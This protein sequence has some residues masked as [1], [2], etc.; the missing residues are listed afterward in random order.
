LPEAYKIPKPKLSEL[1]WDWHWQQI[2]V[3]DDYCSPDGY[4]WPHHQD[5]A[6]GI[7]TGVANSY[8]WCC[9]P[10]YIL[11]PPHS[12]LPDYA[13]S[14]LNFDREIRLIFWLSKQGDDFESESRVML[15]ARSSLGG[16]SPPI[17]DA[18]GFGILLDNLTLK[19]ESYG[20]AGLG[21]IDLGVCLI[22][23]GEAVKVEIIHYPGKRVEYWI[24]DVLRG[25]QTDLTKIPSGTSSAAADAGAEIYVTLK[26]GPTGGAPL[27]VHCTMP[28]VLQ[29]PPVIVLPTPPPLTEVAKIQFSAGEDSVYSLAIS[30]GY[31]YAGLLTSPGKVVKIDLSTFSKVS[32][33]TLDVAEEYVYSLAVSGGYLYA[34]LDTSPG[35]IV[36]IDLA[37]FTKVSSLTLAGGENYAETLVV[38]GNYLYAGLWTS[39]AKIVKIDLSTFTKVSTLTLDVA[40]SLVGGIVL[41]DDGYLYV[42]TYTNPAKIVK[43]D[44]ASLSKVSTL[45]LAAGEQNVISLVT[46]GNFLYAG[47]YT[48][49]GTPK[50]VKVDLTTFTKVSVLTSYPSGDGSHSLAISG[51]YLYAPLYNTT[52]AR[53]RQVSLTTFTYT[54]TFTFGS[55]EN[56]P[57]ALLISGDIIYVGTDTSPA[58]LVK[59]K[60]G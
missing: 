59:V 35:K 60:I 44:P 52:P 53:L 19:G 40:E 28:L 49:G 36:K 30:G 3:W 5:C 37:T 13:N 4:T 54:R 39:P 9:G 7:E 56:Y 43:I 6:V 46:L 41:A 48:A 45:T 42:G 50:H 57:Y 18:L 1:V 33:L 47:L 14:L 20:S 16:P 12:Y 23:G 21:Q 29:E 34:A 8:A 24:D 2:H 38:S 17:L 25:T 10:L 11:G 51:G 31:L 32:T 58:Y 27:W 15:K 22:D 55:G 26:N